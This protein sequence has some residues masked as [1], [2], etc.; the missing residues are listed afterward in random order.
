MRYYES[1]Y[2]INLFDIVNMVRRYHNIAI[3]SH[4]MAIVKVAR[5]DGRKLEICSIECWIKGGT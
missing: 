3:Y 1:I 2:K 4:V 5:E